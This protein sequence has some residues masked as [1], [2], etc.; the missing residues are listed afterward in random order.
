M[1]YMKNI[2][3]EKAKIMLIQSNDP[4]YKIAEDIGFLD[5][6]YFSRNFKDIIGVTPFEYRNKKRIIDYT[7]FSSK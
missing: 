5:E 7:T 2:R 3:L 4:I 6:K 1:A